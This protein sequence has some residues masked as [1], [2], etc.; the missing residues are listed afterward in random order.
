MMKMSELMI[1][2]L[3][4]EVDPF[5]NSLRPSVIEAVQREMGKGLF[6]PHTLSGTMIVDNVLTLSFTDFLPRSFALQSLLTIPFAFMAWLCP[7]PTIAQ[8]LNSFILQRL[9]K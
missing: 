1:G 4:W 7:S 3:L 8:E 6:N 5:S 2:D 9:G